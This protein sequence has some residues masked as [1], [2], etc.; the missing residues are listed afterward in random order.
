MNDMHPQYVFP[1]QDR[2]LVTKTSYLLV[3]LELLIHG[4]CIYTSI[5]HKNLDGIWLSMFFTVM[6]GLA[7]YLNLRYRKYCLA[8]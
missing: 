3:P 8:K 7:H 4:L 6:F 2:E 1:K 5:L